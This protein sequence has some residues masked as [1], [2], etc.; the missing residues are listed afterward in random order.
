MAYAG[1]VGYATD[2]VSA[3][4]G[5]REEI[6]NR[7]GFAAVPAVK[8][9]SVYTCY[10]NILLG[11]MYFVGVAYYAKWFYPELFED[12]KPNAIHQEYLTKFLRIDYDLSKHGVFVYHPEQ[13]P[14]GR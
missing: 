14:D 10:S 12:L 4:R 1:K 6:M 2:D 8:N 13:H 5:K 11:S 9:G 3:L 7:P